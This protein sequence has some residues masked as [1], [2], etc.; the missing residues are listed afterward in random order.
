MTA[1]GVMPAT[2]FKPRLTAGWHEMAIH[3]VR[4]L[5]RRMGSDSLR[6]FE[7]RLSATE[8][9]VVFTERHPMDGSRRRWHLSISHQVLD[10]QGH[11]RPGRYPTWDEIKDARY[12]FTPSDI[13][14]CMILPRPQDFVNVHETCFHLHQHF[15]LAVGGIS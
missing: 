9:L 4:P 3:I 10:E 7:R 11:G 15:D 8:R 6:V 12:R 14:M 13:E 1:P 2:S 5:A